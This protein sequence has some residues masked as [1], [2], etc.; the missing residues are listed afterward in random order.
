MRLDCKKYVEAFNLLNAIKENLDIAHKNLEYAKQRW[1]KYMGLMGVTLDVNDTYF[2]DAFNSIK[3]LKENVEHLQYA[4]I[5]SAI[6]D[7][8][9]EFKFKE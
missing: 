8:C 9:A 2:A 7:G 6:K 1:D 4:L 3:R 5:V